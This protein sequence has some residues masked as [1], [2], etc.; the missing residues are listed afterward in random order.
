MIGM[1]P[2]DPFSP[3][4]ESAA[5]SIALA[6][7]HASL[8]GIFAP[9]TRHV[10]YAANVGWPNVAA[11]ID[12]LFDARVRGDLSWEEFIKGLSAHGVSFANGT[13]EEFYAPHDKAW[14][15]Y[16]KSRWRRPDAALLLNL[17][18]RGFFDDPQTG[19]VNAKRLEE[20]LKWS[21]VTTG[22]WTEYVKQLQFTFTELELQQLY[23][24]KFF[25]ASDFY[26]RLRAVGV[27]SESERQG[28]EYL[29][30]VIPP[31]TELAVMARRFAFADKATVDAL[32]LDEE[33]PPDFLYW[34]ARQG[35]GRVEGYTNGS[36]DGRTTDFAQNTWRIHWNTIAP[37]LA[38]QFY[39]R[40]RPGRDHWGEDAA[41]NNL[42]FPLGDD[43]GHTLGLK[44]ALRDAGYT[45]PFRPLL[46]AISYRLFGFR[47]LAQIQYFGL[48]PDRNNDRGRDWLKNRLQDLGYQEQMADLY[49]QTVIKSNA[50]RKAAAQLD[51]TRHSIEESW[52][53]GVISDAGATQLL[54]SIGLS[55]EEANA[56][57]Q[58]WDLAIR[59]DLVKKA[60]SGIRRN[61]MLGDLTDADAMSQMGNIGVVPTRIQNYLQLW[62]I[63]QR[64]YRLEVS[65]T[66]LTR[67]YA[68]GTITESEIRRRM[69]NIGWANEDLDRI[70]EGAYLARQ[71]Y[72]DKQAAKQ[73]QKDKSGG[74]G[75]SKPW[76]QLTR[77]EIRAMLD[78]NEI[79]EAEA[80]GYLDQLGIDSAIAQRLLYLWAHDKSLKGPS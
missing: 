23:N 34:A 18:A 32:G 51:L 54:Q 21:N 31:P 40:L 60:I 10:T 71:E 20:L 41:F 19:K 12:A 61:Y 11:P 64:Q 78:I 55:P 17:V 73:K 57:V 75:K 25:Q 29:S 4:G 80:L 8:G 52:K 50:Q 43:E 59:H 26:G 1:N 69:A 49:A 62:N 15:S 9:K 58:A 66:T 24:R 76:R 3:I 72:L 42:Y 68:I 63:E 16:Y 5:S 48:A 38:Y 33:T 70:M 35:F 14:L 44:L 56:A 13:I 65:V 74:G 37:T 45:K 53:L 79:T 77:A 39:Q 2:L 28:I 27:V 46:A 36:K 67:W 47:Q 7:L 22:H 6:P 30:H